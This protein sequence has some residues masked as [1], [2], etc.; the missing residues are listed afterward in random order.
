[1]PLPESVLL[2]AAAWGTKV[3]VADAAAAAITRADLL[4]LWAVGFG[5][6]GAPERCG[7]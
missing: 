6:T 5:T 3:T 1:M 2:G 7:K 4:K